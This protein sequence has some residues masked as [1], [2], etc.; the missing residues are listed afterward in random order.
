MCVVSASLCCERCQIEKEMSEVFK[1]C[2]VYI[3][4][5]SYVMSLC[6]KCN[7]SSSMFRSHIQVERKFF[8]LFFFLISFSAADSYGLDV[9]HTIIT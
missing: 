5:M 8:F 4:S 3:D 6:M 7:I 1:T 9:P 2:S